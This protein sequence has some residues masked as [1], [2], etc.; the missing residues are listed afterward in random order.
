MENGNIEK[1]Y[2]EAIGLR[3]EIKDYGLDRGVGKAVL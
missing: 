2:K 1:D 3:L